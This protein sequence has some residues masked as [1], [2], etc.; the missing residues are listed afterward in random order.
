MTEWIINYTIISNFDFTKLIAVSDSLN[1]IIKEILT[2]LLIG[3]AW[4]ECSKL[5]GR[6]RFEQ[7]IIHADYF[8]FVFKFF[9]LYL[10]LYSSFKTTVR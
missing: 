1:P 6:F 3:D 10:Q 5:N 2:G 9:V 8:F 4:I 7:S